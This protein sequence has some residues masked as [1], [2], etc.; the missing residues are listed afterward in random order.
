[1]LDVQEITD[2]QI[3]TVSVWHKEEI[4]NSWPGL[5]G[6]IC[7]QH[8]F[9]FQ[10]WHEEDKARA[11]DASDAQIA[12]VKRS[13]DQLNQKRND[14]IERIDDGI[15]ALIQQRSILTA[16]NAPINTETPGSVI[17]RLS[18][19]A[20]RIY[21]LNEQVMR[22]DASESHVRN[23]EPKLALCLIQHNELSAALQ[24]LLDDIGAG[25]VRHRTYRQ[26]KMYNDPAMNPYLYRR[27]DQSGDDRIKAA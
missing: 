9:N 6:I 13:I 10:L 27:P 20:L 7:E 4:R 3:A 1:M 11:P 19:L 14:W 25:I 18:I 21:H 2:L 12:A 16:P 15:E 5:L 23:V 8:S 24:H 17:D 26:F 22:V